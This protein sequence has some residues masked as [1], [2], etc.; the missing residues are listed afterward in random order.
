MEIKIFLAHTSEVNEDIIKIKNLIQSEYQKDEKIK[1][2]IEHYSDADKSLNDATFQS[3]LNGV[4]STCEILYVFFHDRIGK[5]TKEE[6][7][8]GYSLFS[9]GNKPYSMSVFSKDFSINLRDSK[10][11]KTQK[12]ATMNYIETLKAKDGNQYI[13]DYENF[14]DLNNEFLK[15]LKTDINKITN[16]EL[17]ARDISIFN[18]KEAICPIALKKNFKLQ[19]R[20]TKFVGRKNK[21]NEILGKLTNKGQCAITGVIGTGGIGKSAI[22]NEIA[23][24]IIESWSKTNEYLQ[25]PIFTD[26]ILWVKLEKEQTFSNVYQEQIIKQMGVALDE[27][28]LKKCLSSKDIL[29]VLDSAEQNIPIA[30]EL[31]KLFKHFSIL[32]TSRRKLDDM[33]EVKLNTLN[34]EESIKLFEKHLDRTLSVAEKNT[35]GKFCMTRLGGMPLAIKIVANY[36]RKKGRDFDE[37]KT[38]LK[39]NILTLD[40][41]DRFRDEMISMEAIFELSFKDISPKAQ[42]IFAIGGIYIY[43]FKEE[44]LLAIIQK[45]KPDIDSIGDE[46]DELIE[47]SLIERNT[48]GLYSYHP[49]LRD[50][51]LN[52]LYVF[53]NSQAII[54]AKKEDFAT[55]S[56]KKD[57]LSFIYNELFWI[58]DEDYRD[59]NYTRFIKIVKNLDWWLNDN[60]FLN[61][62]EELLLQGY[63][64]S[65]KIE[66]KPNEYY[67]LR[68]Y[69][70][71]L[72][73]KGE[74]Q[75]AKEQFENAMVFDEAKSDFWL[76][77]ALFTTEYSLSNYSK[78]YIHNLE[79]SRKALLSKKLDDY[80]SFLKTNGWVCNKFFKFD[81]S[82]SLATANCFRVA[83][84]NNN[85]KSLNDLID[86]QIKKNNF[87]KALIYIESLS[88]Y[89]GNKDFSK[90]DIFEIK[91]YKALI[92]LYT[93]HND[94][95]EYIRS[96]EKEFSIF[97]FIKTQFDD[98][99]MIEGLHAIQHK[100]FENAKEILSK[101]D[102]KDDKEFYLAILNIDINMS[103]A[104]SFFENY[105]QRDKLSAN[106]IAQAKLYLAKIYT[107]GQIYKKAIQYLCEA[108][109]MFG[110]FMTPIQK[111]VEQEII[112]TIGSD[113]YTDIKSFLVLNRNDDNFFLENLPKSIITK[114]NKKMILISE[115]FSIYGVDNFDVPTSD[116]IFDNPDMILNN[117]KKL[118]SI[119]YLGNFYMDEEAVS[120]GEYIAYLK[121]NDRYISSELDSKEHHKL[122][123]NL[124]FQE[125]IE[126]ATF[127]NKT[128][129]LPEEWEKAYRGEKN[130]NYPW[131]DEWNDSINI[132]VN[133]DD[134]EKLKALFLD[135][136]SFKEYVLWFSEYKSNDEFTSLGILDNISFESD[137][138]IDRYY[139]FKLLF[140]SL[141]LNTLEK[142]KVI[143]A[144]P[145]LS[146]FQLD[147]LTRVWK[148]EIEKF[149][150][151]E[152]E[153]PNDILRLFIKMQK[154][155]SDIIGELSSKK[156]DM[157]YSTSPYGIKNML[158]N[159][160]ELTLREN[161]AILKGSIITHNY[162]EDLKGKTESLET[163]KL[164]KR[165]NQIYTRTFFRCVKPI[166]SIKDLE[167][168]KN[169]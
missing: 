12:Q 54:E 77:Y 110:E 131:G 117:D 146:Q 144:I 50:Y 168:L 92:Y 97:E 60:G 33:D 94:L 1:L 18:S 93:N 73:R 48:N 40:M 154:E 124:T 142:I 90:A 34:E 80:S 141:S 145:V 105:L 76:Y 17:N 37:I 6:L 160:Y 22:T 120:V 126:Y 155:A 163:I 23:H 108:Q 119:R 49:L 71:A 19:P 43:P 11:Q 70:D 159:G 81:L 147:E 143:E 72:N 2:I 47:I 121:D 149:I 59:E 150:D 3:R 123:S 9:G 28:K 130:W 35:I 138:N 107:K 127:Y 133:E 89:E 137:I 20:D 66:D 32:I 46:I 29:V 165:G 56:G 118:Q 156:D 38:K 44:F 63:Q 98:L 162:K 14:N 21:I 100:Q 58:L 99:R 87:D 104:K 53:P 55:L 69:G 10:E 151:L 106:E 57:Y 95:I 83:S 148:E 65:Q 114:D 153:H 169:G 26:G 42:Q 5:H 122:I 134:F 64:I 41:Q 129:P 74:Y 125:M 75:K 140:Y 4:L 91:I 27:D 30:E 86:I 62:R 15:Q 135:Y 36:M 161:E 85:F 7:E 61:R 115:G 8:I 112:D 139:F 164:D 132:N 79:W 113:M 158:R 157:I 109:E 25:K 101:I 78:S 82:L 13:F 51:A 24:C 88:R 166:F 45:E 136:D 68:S 16:K 96:L 102:D 52:K 152:K 84:V 39:K 103:E 116:E 67:F 111:Q 128:L 167:E 31:M